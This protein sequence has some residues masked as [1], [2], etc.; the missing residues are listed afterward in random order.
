M[1]LSIFALTLAGASAFVQ[2]ALRTTSKLATSKVAPAQM[3]LEPSSVMQQSTNLLAGVVA[4]GAPPAH[5][6]P[7]QFAAR[8]AGVAGLTT[9]NAAAAVPQFRATIATLTQIRPP[10]M[11][12]RSASRFRSERSLPSSSACSFQWCFW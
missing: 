12:A 7:A 1:R 11:A 4:V 9:I 3:M 8:A 6:C 10:Q 2:P 5:P